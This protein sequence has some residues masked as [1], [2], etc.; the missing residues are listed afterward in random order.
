M[1]NLIDT[2]TV[3]IDETN[4]LIELHQQKLRKLDILLLQQLKKEKNS[5]NNISPTSTFQPNIK[6]HGSKPQFGYDDNIPNIGST[7]SSYYR[8]S[9]NPILIEERSRIYTNY[10]IKFSRML[11]LAFD[12]FRKRNMN[13]HL[14]VL[15]IIDMDN[16]LHL[17]DAFNGI[18]LQTFSLT[19]QQPITVVSSDSTDVNFPIFASASQ[20]G[21]IHLTTLFVSS[22]EQVHKQQQQQQQGRYDSGISA[23]LLPGQQFIAQAS[24]TIKFILPLYQYN[25]TNVLLDTQG[26]NYNST[27]L[28]QELAYATA[29]SVYS[30]TKT[31]CFVYLGDNFGRLFKYSCKG[32]LLQFLNVQTPIVI[33]NKNE[34]NDRSTGTKVESESVPFVPLLSETMIRSITF[35]NNWLAASINNMA[36]VIDSGKIR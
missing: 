6:S 36:Y 20:D 29:L 33:N 28:Y 15:V 34:K 25:V 12:P 9:N 13:K 2:L 24:I 31:A 30:R 14:K 3:E 7:F 23:L 22:L 17:Y 26:N 1:K 10:K 4:K 21:L 18:E 32:R 35:A 5:I 16:N 27:T 8:L 19:H 11:T